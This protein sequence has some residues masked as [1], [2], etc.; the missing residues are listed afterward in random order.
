MAGAWAFAFKTAGTA[1][2]SISAATPAVG[3]GLKIPSLCEGPLRPEH[4]KTRRDTGS[5]AKCHK[6]SWALAERH[7]RENISTDMRQ[8][9]TVSGFEI[10]AK[11]GK[12]YIARIAEEVPMFGNVSKWV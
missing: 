10:M 3:H 9:I 4:R 8:K 6:R 7:G 5:A 2:L 11:N 1:V 12:N